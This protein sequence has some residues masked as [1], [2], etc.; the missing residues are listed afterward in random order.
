MTD[1]MREA[2]LRWFGHVKRSDMDTPVRRCLRLAIADFR[3]DRGRPKK[4]RVEVIRRT[5]NIFSLL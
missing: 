1:K 5:W 4:N 2:R 3:R